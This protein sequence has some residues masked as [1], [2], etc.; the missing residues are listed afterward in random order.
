MP[1][2]T[3]LFALFFGSCCIGALFAPMAGVIGYMSMYHIGY[4][5]WMDPLAHLSIRYSFMLAL[6]LGIGTVLHWSRLRYGKRFMTGQEWL[7][8][9]MV[10]VL[11]L[12]KYIG[13]PGREAM[14]W[15]DPDEV[16]ITKVIVF[17]LL[18]THV[19][20]TPRRLSAVLWVLTAGG[21]YLGWLAFTAGPGAFVTGRVEGIGG[22]DFKDANFFGVHLAAALPVI[23]VQFM[24]SDWRAKWLPVLAAAF[25]VNGLIMTRSRG[26]FLAAAIGGVLAVP[27]APKRRRGLILVVLLIGALGAYALTDPGFIERMS[28]I[29]TSPEKMDK[30][31]YGRWLAW[32]T[33]LSM[34]R[35]RPWGFG[36]G[37]FPRYAGEYDAALKQRDPHNTFV[38]CYVELGVQGLIVLLALIGNA[39]YILWKAPRLAEGTADERDVRYFSYAL[40][41]ALAIFLAGG[42][43]VTETYIEELWWMLALPVCLYRVAENARADSEGRIT[44]IEEP[45]N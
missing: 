41:L 44:A 9:A 18:L 29:E 3:I 23:A 7:L 15:E 13:L 35:D 45:G 11:W 22:P 1:L 24:R 5:W 12:S 2:K 17:A 43:T 19:V 4:R 25:A 30:S 32:T 39:I 31:S 33:S 10:G 42:M 28:T 40:L 34:V 20:T 36:A 16:K 27:L 37:N 26:A 6:F 38:K 21:L 14:P 8:L